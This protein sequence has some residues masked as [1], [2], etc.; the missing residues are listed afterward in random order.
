MQ[1][2][3]DISPFNTLSVLTSYLKELLTKVYELTNA[4]V[5]QRKELE[6]AKAEI[7]RLKNL[8]KKPTIKAS[9]LDDP[10]KGDKSKKGNKEEKESK[11]R[12]GSD[13]EKKQANLEIH[14]KICVSAEEIP[15]DW[16][17]VGYKRRIIQDVI[18]QANNIS[19]EL[20]IW[21]SPDG[22]QRKEAKLPEYL[23]NTH[24]GP[25][26]KAYIL[27]QYYECCVSQPL[28]YSTL[29]D[30]GVKIST[31]QISN[32]LIEDKELYHAEKASLLAKA[33]ELAEELRTDDTGAR[34]QAK[35]GYCNCIS[36]DLF[37]YFTTSYSKSRINFLEILRM[38]RED[39][40]LN[41]TA[42]DYMQ[43]EK[44]PTKYYDVLLGS[45]RNG[46]CNFKDE[47]SLVAYFNAHNFTAA[48]AIRTMTQGLLIGCLVENGFDPS[49][50]I[51]SDGAGQFNLFVHSLCWKHAERPLVKLICVTKWQ[52]QQLEDKKTAFW[53]LYQA[54]KF[55]KKN[56]T[57][58]LAQELTKQFDQMCEP[59][60]GFDALNKILVSLKAKESQLLLVL[61]RPET[62]LHNN[63]TEGDIR[64]YAKRRKLSAGTR[65]EN[66]RKAR[67]TFLSLKKTCR[68]LEISFWEYLLDRLQNKNQILPLAELMALK[69]AH[70]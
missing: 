43:S 2:K 15:A 44:L 25:T 69:A 19:Y 20:E 4:L 29:K 46:N 63:T 3:S 16:K 5:A 70:S 33:I 53:T 13:K 38:D 41:Q 12:K 28:I 54:L 21:E 65:S 42:L 22:L 30:L 39:Y 58:E 27:H 7:R 14:N 31:G 57:K 11:R 40:V 64:E 1:E 37:T 32:I 60:V 67:D 8:P 18:I 35:N 47:A 52:E 68:K 51:H 48:Y 56:P 24:F 66:G 23:E 26:L 59:V 17:L 6:E 45:Y 9:K 55:Y 50:G 62:S 34:H 49:I 61:D 36:S 10:I